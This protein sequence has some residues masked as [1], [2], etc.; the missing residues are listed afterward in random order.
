MTGKKLDVTRR[1][2]LKG[3]GAALGLAAAGSVS[4]AFG[5]AYPSRTIDVVVPTREGGGADRN[6]RAVTGV[7]KKYLKGAV[8]EAAFFP[9]ASGR[10]G[11]EVFMNKREP[12]C[13]NLLLGNMGPEVLN[14][15]VQPP[16][17]FKFP[18]DYQYFARV[19]VDPSVVFVQVDGPFK[20]IDDVVAEGKKRTLS[21]ATSRL[22]HPASVGILALGEETG[23]KF[24]L[25]PLSGGRNTL[26]G[27]VTGET[28]IGVLPSGSV[29]TR[30]D[31][32]R[33]LLVFNDVNTLGERLNNAPTV[34]DHFGT[35]LPPLVSARAFALH[36]KAIEDFPDRFA[37]LS[38]TIQQVF[39][40]PEFKAAIEK[41]GA[42]WEN[43]KY[44][45]PAECNAYVEGIVAIGNRFKSLLT[46]KA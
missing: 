2:V 10:V 36:T 4:R 40:D 18:G 24:N 32:V 41:T 37:L 1:T 46:G 25:I 38:E 28:D 45:S 20:T 44:G 22:A 27:V 29:V 31:V 43:I 39:T 33:T 19:D 8:F 5:Q 42:P 23:A 13:Y 17:S 7:W 3:S 14:W 16:E 26:A 30:G 11:Y 15:V 21:V 6:L 35:S 12:D 9:G 34:N